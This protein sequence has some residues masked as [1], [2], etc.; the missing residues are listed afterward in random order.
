MNVQ[1]INP[2]KYNNRPHNNNNHETIGYLFQGTRI[3]YRTTTEHYFRIYSRVLQIQCN[4]RPHNNNNHNTIG[5][6][7]QE[8]RIKYRTI[9]ENYFP[10]GS[11]LLQ[12]QLQVELVVS[13]SDI[14]LYP[15]KK[16]LQ[17]HTPLKG[18]QQGVLIIMLPFHRPKK[19]F[20][21]QQNSF[22]AH[23]THFSHALNTNWG[24]FF[25]CYILKI[26]AL[27]CISILYVIVLNLYR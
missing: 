6:L 21:H 1:N 10:I 15:G 14:I 24:Q 11:Q 22:S 7:F 18:I 19:E 27:F 25:G 12:L 4:N 26:P 2:E 5:Y 23:G 13:D 20:L 17:S 16:T 3:I 8:I 9:T